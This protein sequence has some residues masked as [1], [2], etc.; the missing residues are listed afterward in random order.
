MSESSSSADNGEAVRKVKKRWDYH[1]ELPIRVSPL[2][3]RPFKLGALIRWYVGSWFPLS[4]KLILVALAF[5]SWFF[6]HPELSRCVNFEFGWFSEILLRNMILMVLVAGCLHL[7]LYVFRA[8][9]TRRQYDARPLLKKNRVFT[10]NNQVYDNIFWTCAS[11]VPIWSAYEAFMMWGMANGMVP[12]LAWSE[13]WPW[14]VALFFFIPIWE[15]FYF[16][17]IHRLLHIPMLYRRF[18]SLHHRNTNVGPWSGL[19]MHPVEHVLFLGSVMI[20]W[21]IP[22]NPALIIYHLQYFT[23][24]A[25]TTHAGFEGIEQ[26]GKKRLALGTFHHQLHHRYY[27]CNYGGLEIPWDKWFGSFHDG[28]EQS[29]Q[30]FLARRRLKAEQANG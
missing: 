26:G 7:Y 15:T 27:E 2:F 23:L 9:G 5:L 28:T 17:L 29:H 21:L 19:S 6:F 13:N 18:H 12:N 14:L 1:P 10:F 24:T 3:Q 11:G 20:H 16:Y 30:Q 22:A 4:E 8:Q 25:A